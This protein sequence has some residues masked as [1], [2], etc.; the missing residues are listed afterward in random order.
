MAP[1]SVM[2]RK[3]FVGPKSFSLYCQCRASLFAASL[4]L[5][6]SLRRKPLLWSSF[7]NLGHRRVASRYASFS[8]SGMAAISLSS[9]GNISNS[10]SLSESGPRMCSMLL[11]PHPSEIVQL[12]ESSRAS[13]NLTLLPSIKTGSS[14]GDPVSCSALSEPF[15]ELSFATLSPFRSDSI[16]RISSG[17][18]VAHS[19]SSSRGPNNCAEE[20]TEIAGVK[21]CRDEVGDD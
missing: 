4:A 20:Q 6:F 3:H 21:S 16:S 5:K 2:G 7:T 1:L 15:L 14:S 8:G 13:W 18:T 17:V 11:L 12:K 10:L 19:R 9:S